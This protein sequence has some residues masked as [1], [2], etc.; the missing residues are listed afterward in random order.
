M[1]AHVLPPSSILHR[2]LGWRKRRDQA[3][4]PHRSKRWIAPLLLT[5]AAFSLAQQIAIGGYYVPTTISDP[6]GVT[7]GP[8][9]AAPPSRNFTS[10]APWTNWPATSPA[11]YCRGDES[12]NCAP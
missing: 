2:K 1:H 11:H 6:I 12:A 10:S 5:L 8:P 9:C 4:V 3:I 7:A